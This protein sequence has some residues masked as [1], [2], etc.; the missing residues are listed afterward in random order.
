MP[1]HNVVGFSSR[2]HSAVRLQQPPLPPAF[3]HDPSELE[4]SDYGRDPRFPSGW[5]IVP[6]CFLA[7]FSAVICL[8]AYLP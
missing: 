8:S 5:W 7:V 4:F 3:R 2:R 6:G 1:A